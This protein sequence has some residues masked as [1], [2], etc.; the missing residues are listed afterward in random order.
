[1]L[2]IKNPFEKPVDR[3]SPSEKFGI[4]FVLLR[5]MAAFGAALVAPWLMTQATVHTHALQST[6]LLLGFSTIV[7]LTLLVNLGT[8]L[9]ATLSTTLAS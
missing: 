6:P 9:A 4:V 7:L 3:P 2:L 1:M 5:R 8:G